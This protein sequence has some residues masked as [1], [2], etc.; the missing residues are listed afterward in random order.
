M[1]IQ[2]IS[3]EIGVSIIN[4]NLHSTV[5]LFTDAGQRFILVV[6]NYFIMI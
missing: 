3:N 4:Y 6:D 1:K 2:E 5:K